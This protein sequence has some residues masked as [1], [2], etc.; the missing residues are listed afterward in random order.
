M[1]D[2]EIEA[3][4]AGGGGGAGGAGRGAGAGAGAGD[5]VRAT[6]AEHLA[7]V[8]ASVS[9]GGDE[10][11]AELVRAGVRHLHAFVE[12]VGLQREEWAAGIGFLTAVGQACDD[13][14]Q[15]F[16]LLSDVLGVSMLV[17]VVAQQPAA[18]AT[19]PTVLG[20]FHV[21][22]A[23]R[24]PFGAS[25]VDTDLGGEPL[26]VRGVVRSLGGGPLPGAVLDVWQTAPDGRY[27][28]QDEG[29]QAPGN[30]R[31]VLEADEAG[32]YEFRTVRPV[33]YQVPRDG[34][35]GALLAATGRAG[36]R[37]AH[38]HLVVSAPGHKTV[39]THAFDATSAHLADDTV[40]GVRSSL[41]VDLSQGEA[42]FDVVLE[43]A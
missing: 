31:G 17:E 1:G 4:G 15:E 34:P 29:V 16:V 8:L 13:L 21:E 27:D 3:A 30:L 11:L 32:R 36:W 5:V 35:V 40:F 26:V 38:L 2:R 24:R 33:D 9:G 25:L 18:G 37:P 6:A 20:P 12:E 14:R 19:E 23:P 28:V 39:V 41:V 43:P 10:R 42:T 7:Q 22:G